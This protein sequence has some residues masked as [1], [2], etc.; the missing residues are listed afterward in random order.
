MKTTT[1][2]ED[3]AY[4]SASLRDSISGGCNSSHSNV[5]G[6][7]YDHPTTLKDQLQVSHSKFIVIFIIANEY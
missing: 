3:S 4:G 2:S 1:G 7:D 5:S 6:L